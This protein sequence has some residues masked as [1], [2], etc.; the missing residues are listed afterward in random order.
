[1]KIDEISVDD[2]MLEVGLGLPGKWILQL[3]A[4]VDY[5]RDVNIAMSD[6]YLLNKSLRGKFIFPAP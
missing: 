1:M 5:R 2:R 4:T 3:K 6:F